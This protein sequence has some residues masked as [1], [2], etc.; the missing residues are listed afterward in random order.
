MFETNLFVGLLTGTYILCAAYLF[1]GKFLKITS[2]VQHRL[3]FLKAV[4]FG[5]CVLDDFV[6]WAPYEDLYDLSRILISSEILEMTL[7]RLEFLKA[8]RFGRYVLNEL[9]RWASYGGLHRLRRV[10]ISR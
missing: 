3:E 1:L 8:V 4:R 5:R 10:F 6:C 7:R 9:V 2:V